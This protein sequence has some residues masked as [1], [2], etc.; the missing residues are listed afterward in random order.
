MSL[1]D[2]YHS[3]YSDNNQLIARFEVNNHYIK[4]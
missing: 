1:E 4:I 2:Q 3:T